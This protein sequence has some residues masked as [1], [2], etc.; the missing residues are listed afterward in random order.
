MAILLPWPFK[1]SSDLTQPHG[2]GAYTRQAMA[3]LALSALHSNTA[4]MLS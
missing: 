2:L 3:A 4:N 1:G